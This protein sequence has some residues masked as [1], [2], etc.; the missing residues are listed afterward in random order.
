MKKI[1]QNSF[2][3][4]LNMDLNPLSTP[5]DVLTDC[6]NGTIIT[7][8][9]DDFNIQTELG[10]V[11]V[12]T[13]GVDDAL[14][15]GFIPLGI[16]EFN[17]IMYIVAHNPFTKETS[18]GSLPSPQRY[19][20]VSDGDNKSL[21]SISDISAETSKGNIELQQSISVNHG[22]N[23]LNAFISPGDKFKIAITLVG[24]D[25]WNTANQILSKFINNYGTGEEGYF[26]FKYYTMNIDGSL[27]VIPVE[28]LPDFSTESSNISYL[29]EPT[30]V[31]GSN[32]GKDLVYDGDS[33]G[34]ITVIMSPASIKS[35]D[36]GLSGDNANNI[37]KAKATFNSEFIEYNSAI[38]IKTIEIKTTSTDGDTTPVK[39]FDYEQ[40]VITDDNSPA[41]VLITKKTENDNAVSFASGTVI[42]VTCTPIDQF[43]RRLENFAK[44]KSYVVSDLPMG[45]DAHNHFT[46]KISDAG[47][48]TVNYNF[49]YKGQDTLPTV[50]MEFYDFW[51]NVSLLKENI[52][53]VDQEAEVQIPLVNYERNKTFNG[54]TQGGFPT[55]EITVYSG[56][57]EL[58]SGTRIMTGSNLRKDHCYL[59]RIYGV[60]TGVSY[61]VFQLLYTLKISQFVNSNMHNYGMIDIIRGLELGGKY[62]LNYTGTGILSKG[63]TL[64]QPN[65]VVSFGADHTNYIPTTGHPNPSPLEAYRLYGGP[66]FCEVVDTNNTIKTSDW[67][68]TKKY[69]RNAYT[70]AFV[71]VFDDAVKNIGYHTFSEI[72]TKMGI[73]GGDIAM[74]SNLFQSDKT[75]LTSSLKGAD[76]QKDFQFT[77]FSDC[78]LTADPLT[79]NTTLL[80]VNSASNPVLFGEVDNTLFKKKLILKSLENTFLTNSFEKNIA[81]TS[82]SITTAFTWLTGS[83]QI[84]VNTTAALKA[85]L[86]SS[87]ILDEFTLSNIVLSSQRPTIAPSLFKSYTRSYTRNKAFKYFTWLHTQVVKSRRLSRSDFGILDTYNSYELT[88]T[89]D[90]P[91]NFVLSVPPTIHTLSS[92]RM[93]TYLGNI[94]LTWELADITNSDIIND[95]ITRVGGVIPNIS[96][97]VT[98]E[99]T[100]PANA[101]LPISSQFIIGCNY[102]SPGNLIPQTIYQVYKTKSPINVDIRLNDSIPLL[103]VYN[104]LWL[105]NYTERPYIGMKPMDYVN[106]LLVSQNYPE[107][108]LAQYADKDNI[109]YVTYG[110]DTLLLN[111]NAIVYTLLAQD[112]DYTLKY[113]T[114]SCF[115]TGVLSPFNVEKMQE[116]INSWKTVH[117]T[118][119]ILYNFVDKTLSAGDAKNIPWNFSSKETCTVSISPIG[120]TL[121]AVTPTLVKNIFINAQT[122]LENSSY[123]ISS[124]PVTPS[125]K[126]I[127]GYNIS[128]TFSNYF[129][130]TDSLGSDNITN[131]TI[132]IPILNKAELG[133]RIIT[134]TSNTFGVD[135]L[136]LDPPSIV[137]IITPKPFVIG[138]LFAGGKIAYIDE[139][140]KH[141][142]IAALK[143]QGIGMWSTT[144]EGPSIQDGYD[145]RVIG[146]GKTN[147]DKMLADDNAGASETA[148]RLCSELVQSNYD[149]WY[150]PSIEELKQL[151]LNRVIL[152]GFTGDAYWSSSE[153]FHDKAEYLI[154]SSNINGPN[155]KRNT[156]RVRAIRSF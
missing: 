152:G 156:Y 96:D 120:I 114:K 142:F 99:F 7:Y 153:Y 37:F 13:S 81:F 51:S 20:T 147:T 68:S 84:N 90:V 1:T 26:D 122:N 103:S 46:Y 4:G 88:G 141:G 87:D 83:P 11:K 3:K 118:A 69:Y 108:L 73:T 110:T 27:T 136:C 78:T 92:F 29:P 124:E 18:V 86:I 33:K 5:K 44:T 53:L 76:G 75:Y 23:L 28:L 146:S 63:S 17:G 72:S 2:G 55:S 93:L 97:D 15:Q 67:T 95:T 85:K 126:A 149:D 25:T 129:T 65:G 22:M 100:S 137:E 148:A 54:S 21:K 101:A 145:H 105:S 62:D 24:V 119:K 45:V 151:Y 112:V 132:K 116:L 48:L 9:G 58:L 16:K 131:T 91:Y 10:N 42:T 123:L 144:N 31:L 40:Y 138:A 47:I 140:G 60:E 30:G 139:T 49:L 143:D 8:N 35:F 12:K 57:V 133:G 71:N 50:N 106:S 39:Y 32:N 36:F 43:G 125:I 59:V 113:L 56:Q 34:V 127:S 155:R 135:K 66:V 89:D 104:S 70:K 61:N 128:S 98:S 6:L 79:G 77:I 130:L 52:T 19:I 150:L 80:P 134:T 41:S 74:N 154:F 82:E 109:N 94:K 102:E 64:T 121:D 115:G 38:R 117:P 111:N 14:P 107:V